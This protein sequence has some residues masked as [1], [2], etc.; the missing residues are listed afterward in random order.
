MEFTIALESPFSL[1]LTLQSGQV[2]RWENRGEWWYGVVSGGVI[3]MKQEGD[4]LRCIS[5]SDLLNGAFVRSYFR[6]DDELEQIL[7]SVM[8]EDR[9]T[10]AVQKFY[11]LRLIRQERWECLASFVLATNSNIPRIRKM[12][13]AV[14]SKYGEPLVFEGIRYSSFPKPEVLAAATVA[15]LRECGL[16]YRAPFLKHVASS[17]DE[18]KVDFSELT[19]RDYEDAR[20][21]LLTKLF[22]EKLLLGVGPKVADCVLLYSCEKD[23][24][25]P[26]DVWIA[27]ELATSYPNLL[28]KE[29]KRKLGPERKSKLGR[30]D[31]ERLSASVRS[32]FGEHAGYAQQYLFMMAR[33]EGARKPS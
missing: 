26:I 18:G 11:G 10:Q 14:C 3:K 27:R 6:L 5:G 24:A 32:Y 7:G 15:E 8:K 2:F 25:F 19:L 30:G 29:L 21:I 1:D 23:E 22:G 12:V 20:K 4:S 33:A 28:T 16:G 13:E 17:I 31:Y 9:M